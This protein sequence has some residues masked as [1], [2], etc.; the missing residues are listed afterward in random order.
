MVLRELTMNLTEREAT[1][2][3]YMVALLYDIDYR[4]GPVIQ[5]HHR[6][7]EVLALWHRLGCEAEKYEQQGKWVWSD[8]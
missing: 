2:L 7:P 4:Y 8:D 5:A 3:F 6:K 1:Q